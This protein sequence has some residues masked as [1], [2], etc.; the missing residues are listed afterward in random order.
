MEFG[1]KTDLEKL[2]SIIAKRYQSGMK[3]MA[4]RAPGQHTTN[5]TSD[6]GDIKLS[7]LIS[8]HYSNVLKYWDT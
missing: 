6:D 3:D 2:Y 8:L 4:G 7:R 5:R 1:R